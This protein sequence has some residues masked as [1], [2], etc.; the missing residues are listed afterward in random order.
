M[1]HETCYLFRSAISD[2]FVRSPNEEILDRERK[3][4]REKENKF[5]AKV[6][7]VFSRNQFAFRAEL[8]HDLETLFPRFNRNQSTFF[9]FLGKYYNGGGGSREKE[10]ELKR[11]IQLTLKTCCYSCFLPT[12]SS[13]SPCLGHINP[14]NLHFLLAAK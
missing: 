14:F 9:C 4:K 3:R 13:L 10:G 12:F 11:H 7:A 1:M 2:Q 5:K 8:W 6:R